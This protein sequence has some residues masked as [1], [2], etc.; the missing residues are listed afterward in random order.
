VVVAGRD[1]RAA[2]GEQLLCPGL[3]DLPVFVV[4]CLVH[5]VEEEQL[6]VRLVGRAA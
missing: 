1:D 5:L 2:R 6:G 4:E 3:D